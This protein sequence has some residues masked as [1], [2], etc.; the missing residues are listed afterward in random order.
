MAVVHVPAPEL[1][2]AIPACMQGK[3]KPIQPISLFEQISS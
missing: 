3:K 1:L 2:A